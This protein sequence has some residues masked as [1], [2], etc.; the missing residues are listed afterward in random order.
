MLILIFVASFLLLID[1]TTQWLK[2]VR[3]W[4][5]GTVK[6]VYSLA[7][8]PNWADELIS[9]IHSTSSLKEKNKLLNIELLVLKARL[10]KMA[11]L[12]SENLASG[13]YCMLQ[14]YYKTMF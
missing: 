5:S 3:I 6:P 8:F 11:E 13:I 2:P 14:N 9:D 1:S 12:S 10:Q 4:F 7:L